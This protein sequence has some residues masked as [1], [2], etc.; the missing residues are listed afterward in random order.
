MNKEEIIKNYGHI[1]LRLDSYYK[2]CFYYKGSENG[3]TVIAVI[4]GDSNDIYKW[5]ISVNDIESLNSLDPDYIDII[6][7]GKTIEQTF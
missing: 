1:N 5:K 7:D 6:K 3:I 2:Y 4:G